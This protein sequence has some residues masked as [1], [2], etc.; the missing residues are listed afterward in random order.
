MNELDRLESAVRNELGAREIL[1]DLIQIGIDVEALMR[2]KGGQFIVYE[3][4]NAIAGTLQAL[5]RDDASDAQVLAAVK[6]LRVSYGVLA[7]IVDLIKRGRAAA[8][9]LKD[10]TATGHDLPIY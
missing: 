2:D 5:L 4:T 10:D 6:N 7:T 3:T 1:V 8:E 9:E